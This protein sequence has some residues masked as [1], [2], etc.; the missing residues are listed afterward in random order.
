M[1]RTGPPLRSFPVVEP[2]RAQHAQGVPKVED[3]AR[4]TNIVAGPDHS[5]PSSDDE[6]TVSGL[7]SPTA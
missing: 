4:A 6:T 5:A 2:G 3:F 1:D 7:P